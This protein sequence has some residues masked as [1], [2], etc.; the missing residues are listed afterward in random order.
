MDQLYQ[1]S[2]RLS[3]ATINKLSHNIGEVLVDKNIEIDL[4]HVEEFH[5]ALFDIFGSSFGLLINKVHPY[6]YSF[7]SQFHITSP[8]QL[9]AIA[10]VS[11][12]ASTW[13][14]TKS[15]QNIPPNRK[16]NIQTFWDRTEAF[17]WLTEELSY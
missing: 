6:S 12:S 17:S 14:A 2:T 3:F 1:E 5:K 4:R 9:K 11:Y 15:L 10:V 13:A 8:P 16:K 7:D